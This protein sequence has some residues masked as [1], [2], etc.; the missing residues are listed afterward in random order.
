MKKSQARNYF[1]LL[2]I[3][4]VGYGGPFDPIDTPLSRNTLV[5]SKEYN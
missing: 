2:V 1:V 3:E 5:T 4:L